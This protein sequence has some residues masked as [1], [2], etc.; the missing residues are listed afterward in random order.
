MTPSPKALTQ[1]V[2]KDV[3]GGRGW[4]AAF[5]CCR[6]SWFIQDES[7]E[8]LWPAS[9]RNLS[10]LPYEI[11]SDWFKWLPGGHLLTPR[12]RKTTTI[13]I[14]CKTTTIIFLVVDVVVNA[15]PNFH[16]TLLPTVNLSCSCYSSNAHWG[17][18]K[19]WV[20][21]WSSGRGGQD[22][23]TLPVG[24]CLRGRLTEAGTCT[25]VPRYVAG[26]PPTLAREQWP[27][28]RLQEGPW[29]QL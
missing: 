10:C 6:L 12:Q 25:T 2:N 26:L 18:I 9:Q 28:Q 13:S 7:C 22:A 11:L 4:T 17:P 15:G 27:G 16:G 29:F 3:E 20:R 5:E 21:P 14:E 23:V 8:P 19:A 1:S 24:S